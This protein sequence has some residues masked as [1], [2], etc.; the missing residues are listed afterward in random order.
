[1]DIRIVETTIALSDLRDVAKEFYDDMVKGAVDIENDIAAFGGE[2]HIDASNVLV[3]Q[4]SHQGD[5]WGF[6]VL[7]DQPKES[8]IEYTSLINIRPQA[9]NRGMEVMDAKVRD[10]MKKI[11]D[12]LIV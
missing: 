12:A 10:R 6:N 1:M 7:L 9:G 8:W 5:I 11:L 2:Y 3:E 4:G